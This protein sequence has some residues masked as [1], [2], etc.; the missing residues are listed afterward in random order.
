MSE[1]LGPIY[2]G[3]EQ[4]VFLGRDFSQQSRTYSEAMASKVDQEVHS[5]LRNAYER[6]E[7]ALHD[8]LDK[9]HAVADALMEKET[10]YRAEFEAILA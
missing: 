2:L 5:Y 10:L 3:S 1:E 9:L 8:N 7:K 6:A 4:E